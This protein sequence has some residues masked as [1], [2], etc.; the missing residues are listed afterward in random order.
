MTSV[1]DLLKLLQYS[2]KVYPWLP[3]SANFP[4]ISWSWAFMGGSD[5]RRFQQM[6]L[7][8]RRQ[9]LCT[10]NCRLCALL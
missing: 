2:R 9:W 6:Q 10:G 8:Y 3:I 5:Y 1:R 4:Q 7:F